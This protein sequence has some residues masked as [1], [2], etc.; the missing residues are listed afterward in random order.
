MAE[1]ASNPA[2][3]K[4][5]PG[6]KKPHGEGLVDGYTEINPDG[7]LPSS[8]PGSARPDILFGERTFPDEKTR[9]SVFSVNQA[10]VGQHEKKPKPDRT[11]NCPME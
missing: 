4:G 3:P 10:E 6:T 2:K 9:A 8:M 7:D 1:Y 5:R 11:P